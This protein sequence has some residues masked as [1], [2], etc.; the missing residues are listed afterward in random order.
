MFNPKLNKQFFDHLSKIVLKLLIL[1]SF[2]YI[3]ISCVNFMYMWDV[4]DVKQDIAHMAKYI[5]QEWVSRV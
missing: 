1:S 5:D 2:A 4:L 3:Y